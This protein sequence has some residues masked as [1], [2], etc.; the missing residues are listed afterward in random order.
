MLPLDDRRG[1][2]DLVAI[3]LAEGHAVA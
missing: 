2:L 1:V 3:A